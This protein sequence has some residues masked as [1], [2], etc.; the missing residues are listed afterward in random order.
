[1]VLA[2]VFPLCE[3][4]FSFLAYVRTVRLGHDADFLSSIAN[5]P[6][7]ETEESSLLRFDP[8]AKFFFFRVCRSPAF[9]FPN[10]PN[11]QTNG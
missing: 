2:I 3:L 8:L 4:A 10:Q 11:K 5:E 1:M 7:T 9:L 6:E